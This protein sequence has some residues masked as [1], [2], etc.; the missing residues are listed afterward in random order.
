MFRTIFTTL[1]PLWNLKVFGSQLVVLAETLS[2]P[3]PTYCCCSVTKWS[4]DSDTTATKC[5]SIN[6]L[7]WTQFRIISVLLNLCRAS[8]VQSLH[9]ILKKIFPRK[10]TRG[11]IFVIQYYTAAYQWNFSPLAWVFFCSEKSWGWFYHPQ[12]FFFTEPV[13]PSSLTPIPQTFLLCGDFITPAAAAQVL[14]E[15][16][17]LSGRGGKQASHLSNI[18]HYSS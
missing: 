18:S 13:L 2:Y 3:L 14:M 7:I 6:N 15:P 16:A 5:F 9:S 17:Q 4:E 12:L 10:H 1:W 11:Y 8:A